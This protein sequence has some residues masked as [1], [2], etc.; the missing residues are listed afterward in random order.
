M[1]KLS[2]LALAHIASFAAAAVLTFM[3]PQLSAQCFTGP[4]VPN[5]TG[6][7]PYGPP[8]NWANPNRIEVSDDLYA[9]VKMDAGETSKLLEVRDFGFIL[10]PAATILGITVLVEGHQEAAASYKANSLHLMK[11][12][13]SVGDDKAGLLSF[14]ETTDQTTLLGSPSDTWGETWTAADIMDP[15]FGLLIDVNR[16]GGTGTMEAYIDYLHIIIYYDDGSGCILPVTMQSFTAREVSTGV[17]DLEWVTATETQND[18]F[19]VERSE[20]GI[21]FTSVGTVRGSGTTTDTHTYEFTDGIAPAK[22]T[23]S[24]GELYYRIRQTDLSGNVAYSHVVRVSSQNEGPAFTAAPNPATDLVTVFF[25]EATESVTVELIALD[26]RLVASSSP[27]QGET[28]L[29]L[30]VSGLESGMYVIRMRDPKGGM[31]TSK[32]LVN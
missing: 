10:P 1:K 5:I 23:S 15:F 18:Y 31:S 16:S 8:I 30:D 19:A 4:G 2:T 14:N 25:A 22:T 20:D 17:V 6:N 12:G 7:V 32:I 3:A 29:N 13:V 11:A 28:Q 27:A 21:V 9:R 24:G 26:G